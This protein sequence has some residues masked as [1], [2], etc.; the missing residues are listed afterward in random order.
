MNAN[1]SIMLGL[2]IVIILAGVYLLYFEAN[3]SRWVSIGILSA[4]ILLFVG[5]A[6]MS[7]ASSAPTDPTTRVVERDQR[8]APVK[9]QVNNRR[10]R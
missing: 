4:G 10:D 8:E 9:V 2:G 5:L 1:R 7:F 3:L 6:V